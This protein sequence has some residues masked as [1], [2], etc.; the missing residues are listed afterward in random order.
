[1]PLPPFLQHWISDPPPKFLFEVTEHS[2]A[3]V[4][5][6]SPEA[7]R[8]EALLE[9]GLTASPSAPNI[10]R[11]NLYRE[12]LPKVAILDGTR[13]EHAA[14]V[15]PDY[16]ARMAILDFE[17]FPSK[18][19][20]Q[21]K[22]LRFRLRKSVPFPIEE[23][24]LAYSVQFQ[25]GARVEVLAV[26]I[27]RPI[28]LE[29][30]SLFIDAGFRLG[31]VQPSSLAAL[32]LCDQ[33]EPGLTLMVKA[34]GSTLSVILL[35]EGRVRMIRSLDLTGEEDE[36]RRPGAEA[37][38][39]LLQQTFAYCEDQIGKPAARLMLC[40]FGPETDSLAE[41]A[42]REFA[43]P[44]YPARSRFGI[45]SQENAGLLGLLEQYAA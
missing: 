15:I 18:G 35:D 5:P 13:G 36:W 10:L 45:A 33:E 37:V 7:Q 12:A 44:A 11:P 22:L 40:G 2:L 38:L 20:E 24:Q 27:A 41:N 19:E 1:M 28:L 29:Y 42:E 25:Q 3:C 26:A 6:R 34:A 21:V 32:R 4:S 14:L 16:A 9:A 31:L 43:I 30:E 8:R 17:A 23:A 39:L